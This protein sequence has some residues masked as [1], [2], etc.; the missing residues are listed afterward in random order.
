MRQWNKSNY[1]TITI[2]SRTEQDILQEIQKLSEAYVPEWKFDKENPDIG[3]VISMIYARQMMDNVDKYN[4]ILEQFQVEFVNMLG[5]SLQ[6]AIPASAMVTMQLAEESMTGVP[7]ERGVKLLATTEED[8]QVV[9]ET[10]SPIYIT[11]SKLVQMFMTSARTGKL[12]PLYGAFQPPY[13]I[14]PEQEQEY[15]AYPFGLFEFRE[16]GLEKHGLLLYHSHL[17]DVENSD[18]ILQLGN[19]PEFTE[20]L[21][22]GQYRLQY[23]S[24]EGFA[25]FTQVR[26][27][28]DGC[29]YLQKDKPC[30]KV[31]KNGKDYSVI[32][33]ETCKNPS[34]PVVFSDI[35]LSSFG[36]PVPPAFVTN[37]SLDLN[38]REF[39]PFGD[40]LA[41][42]EEVYIGE[43][44]YFHKPGARITIQFRIHLET[45]QILL[46]KREEEEALK[47]IKRKPRVLVT[48]VMADTYAD[49]V[50]FEYY[51]GVGW[52]RLE[53]QKAYGQM[54]RTEGIVD[55]ELSF[56]CPEDW[57]EQ[58]VGGDS[59]RCIRMQLLKADNCYLRP[60]T[61][62]YPVISDMKIAYAYDRQE[63]R[64]ECLE[65]LAGTQKQ[66]L[67]GLLY[68]EQPIPAFVKGAYSDTALYMGFD[69]KMEAGPISILFELEEDGNFQGTKLNYYYSTRKGFQRLR[70]VDYTNGMTNSNRIVFLPPSDMAPMRLEGKSCYWIKAVDED[71]RLDEE[72]IFRP[73]ISNIYINAVEATNAETLGEEEYYIDEVQPDMSFRLYADNVL[74]VEVWVNE[75]NSLTE[76]VKNKLLAK[77]PEDVRVERDMHGNIIRFFVRWQEVDNFDCSVIGDRHYCVDRMNNQLIFGDGVHVQIPRNT[78]DVSFIVQIT[79]CGGAEGNLNPGMINASMSNL[80]FVNRIQNPMKS[81]GGSDMETMEE[82]LHRG[83]NLISS[84]HRLVSSTD[85]EREVLGFSKNVAQVKTVI[86]Y[87][88]EGKW[89]EQA[90][91]LVVLLQDYLSNPQ[92]FYHIQHRLKEHLLSQCELSVNPDKLMLVPPTFVSVSVELWVEM[93]RME[94]TFEIQNR[95][96]EWMEEYLNPYSSQEWEIGSMPTEAQIRLLLRS[97]RHHLV[98][99][100]ISIHTVY[101]DEFGVHEQTLEELKV[102][103]YMMCRSGN[104]RIHVIQK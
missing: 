66:D 55:Y 90:I 68:R 95:F 103:P 4:D 67:T 57:Q 45:N 87:T 44:E 61:H 14:E 36:K 88:K 52:K 53:C 56:V 42:Y 26:I 27:A 59:G 73:H 65:R 12:I 22:Q 49:E 13:Y 3:S 83:G 11:A 19:Q 28:E 64:P 101:Q 51:N 76:S 104:H 96:Q 7:L 71:G 8:E 78:S 43:N 98:I 72:G 5:V 18:I 75:T 97:G 40:T 20:G 29:L 79:R 21:K 77:Q 74:T 41:L 23:Y 32:L 82:A 70:L 2:D 31:E 92:S 34:Q 37:G 46:T 54:F 30:K 50:T 25:P 17:F 1:N 85:Y 80:L 93:L 6:P 58:S 81:Y 89:D 38:V 39:R 63:A 35:W 62:H 15:Q 9:F 24:E 99:R 48:E 60:C 100:H 86:G 10:E 33:L 84:R 102:N 47:I 91:T 16:T 94:E 69:K